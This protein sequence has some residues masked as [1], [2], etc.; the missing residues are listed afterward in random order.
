M[1]S[2]RIAYFTHDSIM[3]GVGRSQILPLCQELVKAGHSVHLFSFEKAMPER[4]FAS[5]VQENGL[6][7][8]W[9]SFKSGG[10]LSVIER[11]RKLR[12]IQDSFD[13]IHARGDLPALAAVMRRREPVFWDIR[14]LWVEQRQVL[15]PWRFNWL[16]LKAMKL[17]TRYVSK[18]V[19]GFNTLTK[20]VEPYLKAKLPHLPSVHTVVG[21]CVDTDT[22]KLDVNQPKNTIALL[23]GTYNNIYD[24]ELI[25]KLIAHV[26]ESLGH[27]VVWARGQESTSPIQTFERAEV[28]ELDYS[29]IP[30]I[31]SE[32][33]YGIAVC[34]NNLGPSLL[35]AMPTKIAEF[36]AVGRPVIVNS[37]LG[38]V[39]DLLVAKNVAVI[40]DHPSE[41]E[42]AMN[43]V[44]LLLSDADTALRCRQVVEQSLSLSY[45]INSY[46]AAYH[47]IKSL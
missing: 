34:R 4:I 29:E 31:I 23:S 43:D 46:Q 41:I 14:S 27:K 7:W 38:D 24:L 32:S 18:R 19:A 40:L 35:A 33:S 44:L 11:V 16:V 20:A 26:S 47:Q 2:M 39:V 45:A 30:K 28:Y 15:N 5:Q 17:V 10:V 1:N 37:N 12:S 42:Q 36:L 9:Y 3:E 25:S 8:T 21:T 13:L 22:F 6:K